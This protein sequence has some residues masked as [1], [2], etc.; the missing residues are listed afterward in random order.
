[1]RLTP[2]TSTRNLAK[3]LASHA[4]PWT[5]TALLCLPRIALAVDPFHPLGN[6]TIDLIIGRVISVILG[7]MGSIS[8]AMFVYGGITWMTAQGNDE[9]IKKA[10]NTIVYSMLGLVVA[11]SSYAILRTFMN[12]LLQP[13]L[14]RTS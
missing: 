14:R 4:L 5:L 2:E 12:E 8:L 13:A 10:K 1:M 7:L 6:I 3:N 11:F 9:K